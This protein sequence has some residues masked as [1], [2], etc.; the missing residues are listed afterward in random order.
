MKLENMQRGVEL[1]KRHRDLLLYS[2]DLSSDCAKIYVG[3]MH[4]SDETG[5]FKANLQ[6]SI[7]CEIEAVEKE[8]EEL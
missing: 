2:R 3:N 7:L 5:V 6:T 1:V 4:I 8:I